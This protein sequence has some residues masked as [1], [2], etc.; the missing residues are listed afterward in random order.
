[1][2]ARVTKLLLVM[3]LLAAILLGCL[4]MAYGAFFLTALLFGI[5]AVILFRLLITANNFFL[6][7]IYGSRTPPEY[8]INFIQGIQLFFNEFKA[9]MLTSSWS[10]PF[11]SFSKRVAQKSSNL[12]VLLVHG[13]LCNSGQWQT[14]S[15][16]LIENEIT[17]YAVNLEPALES[18]DCFVPII[19]RAIAQICMETGSDKV[20]IVA[21][22][23]GGLAVRAYLRDHGNTHIAKIITLGTP[24]RGTVLAKFAKGKNS[25]QM[26]LI[27]NANNGSC[28]DWLQQLADEEDQTNYDLVVS[29]YSHHDNIIAPQTSSH[30]IGARNIP[31]HGIGHVAL[32]F[33]KAIQAQVVKEIRSASV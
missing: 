12:P 5:S 26:R 9:T 22:S 25:R 18:I 6:A 21:H 1:M 8:K 4:F 20:I 19:H 30:L 11:C 23:M 16:C 10:M 14:L 32:L 31:F 7:W 33:D 28:K 24:H 15:R 17:H 29:L 27:G 2:I 3:Q 13:Y